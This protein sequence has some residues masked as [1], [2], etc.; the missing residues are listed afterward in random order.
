MPSSSAGV[1][2]AQ[3][4]ATDRRMATRSYRLVVAWAFTVTFC[5]AALI[6]AAG[7]LTSFSHLRSYPSE[8]QGV[9]V[10]G[11]AAS[12][13]CGVAFLMLGLGSFLARRR[14]ST[15][16]WIVAAP[17][18]AGIVLLST[19]WWGSGWLARLGWALMRA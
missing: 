16:T 15:H 4:S 17:L 9:E 19:L 10:M 11:F 14:A 13:I 18:A 1:R 6:Y 8:A 3:R 12:G 2:A 5:V 7:A